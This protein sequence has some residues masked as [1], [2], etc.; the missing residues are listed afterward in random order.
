M[1]LKTNGEVVPLVVATSWISKALGLMFRSPKY[2]LLIPL[3]PS[4]EYTIHM[5]FMRFSID[6][7]LLDDGYKVLDIKTL[8]PW[9]DIVK[10]SG[11]RWAL[12][13]RE[14]TLRNVKIG[15]VLEIQ[16]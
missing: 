8:R 15:D 14:G 7:I 1:L 16:S 9:R 6:L 2:G 4:K 11:T 3:D 10:V 13:L 12:E 5:F